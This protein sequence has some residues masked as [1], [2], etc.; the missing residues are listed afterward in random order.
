MSR[1]IF[2]D[3]SVIVEALKGNA[4]A[5]KLLDEI[6]ASGTFCINATVF[7]EI[8]YIYIRESVDVSTQELVR[9]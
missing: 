5:V 2:I 3:S 8:A 6:T 7:S 9:S 4:N 1:R